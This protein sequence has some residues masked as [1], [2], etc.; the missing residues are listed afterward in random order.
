MK[1]KAYI[2][3]ENIGWTPLYFQV[4]G[5]F[6][7]LSEKDFSCRIQQIGICRLRSSKRSEVPTGHDCCRKEKIIKL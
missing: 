2:R 1:V 4:E 3:V 6:P 5:D 7:Q